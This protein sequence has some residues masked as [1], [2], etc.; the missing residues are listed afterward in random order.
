MIAAGLLGKKSGKGFYMHG[1]GD[2]PAENPEVIPMQSGTAASALPP[3]E[4]KNRMVLLMINEAAR[5]LDEGVA[6]EP[7]DVD[8][9]MVMGTGWAPFRGGPLRYADRLGGAHVA[10]E[11]TRLAETVGPHFAP[12]AR[13]ADVVKHPGRFYED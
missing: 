10:A 12:C 5:C 11:L 7:A 3:D 9:A 8:F 13:L 1:Y 6:A 2:T 4:L